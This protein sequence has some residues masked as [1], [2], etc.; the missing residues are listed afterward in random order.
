MDIFSSTVIIFASFLGFLISLYIRHKKSSGERLVCPINSNC[1]AVI[2]SEFSSFFGVSI[3]I[4]GLIYYALIAVTYGAILAFPGA[5]P[6]LVLFSSLAV[7]ATAFLFSGYLT[8]IQIFNLRQFCAWC[9]M[10]ATLCAVIF[11]SAVSG[12]GLELIPLLV[13]NRALILGLHVLGVAVGLGGA[14]IADVFFFK[15]LR[16]FLISESESEILNTLSQIIW[17]ALAL[18][19]VTGAGLYI[20]D[21][22]TLNASP[23]FLTKA[24]VVLVLIIN[25]ALL[26]LLVAPKLVKISFHQKHIHQKDELHHIRKIA[27]ALGGISI[28]SWMSAFLLGSLPRNLDYSLAQFLGVYFSL[29]LA[30]IIGS[31]IFEHFFIRQKSEN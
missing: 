8:F 30:V 19:I 25:G 6:H 3:E 1:D 9:L 15:F 22:E 27:F 29:L 26:N 21:M 18:L 14:I 24:V 17:A 2:H 10:S 5:I 28:T 13:E 16:D 12:S 23:K 7:T 20:Q 11:F 31:Q 4:F